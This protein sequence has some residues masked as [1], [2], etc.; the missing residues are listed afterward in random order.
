MLNTAVLFIL[1]VG[2][3]EI[4]GFSSY[5]WPQHVGRIS[6]SRTATTTSLRDSDDSWMGTAEKQLM[7]GGNDQLE[8]PAKNWLNSKFNVFED[9]SSQISALSD[10]SSKSESLQLSNSAAPASIEKPK[11]TTPLEDDVQTTKRRKI[12]A[13]VHETGYDSMRNYMKTMC[14]HELLNKNEE[15]I[16]AREIQILMQWEQIREELESQLLR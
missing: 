12:R 6:M 3:V 5:S 14:N 4:S 11:T 7:W 10:E 16:L 2:A 13:S 9:F 8:G 1:V 15:I